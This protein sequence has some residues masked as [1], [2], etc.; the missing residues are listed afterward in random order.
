M[1]S[2]IAR[3]HAHRDRSIHV[4]HAPTWRTSRP[5]PPD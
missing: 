5:T 3:I 4:Q 2:V 1:R